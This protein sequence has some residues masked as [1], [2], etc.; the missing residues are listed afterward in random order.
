MHTH[1]QL[2]SRHLQ[3]TVHLHCGGGMGGPDRS[4]SV[5][6]GGMRGEE[7][8]LLSSCQMCRLQC[9]CSLRVRLLW[10]VGAALSVFVQ[11]AGMLATIR[12]QGGGELA[13]AAQERYPGDA[14]IAEWATQVIRRT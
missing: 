5:Q 12:Q 11:L 9:T 2:S 8:V 1:T 13:R 4:P 14:G 3:S 7:L 10:A 6:Y